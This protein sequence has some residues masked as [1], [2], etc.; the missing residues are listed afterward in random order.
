VYRK[1][2]KSCHTGQ[3]LDVRGKEQEE[4]EMEQIQTV[5]IK[6]SAT[7]EATAVVLSLPKD[8]ILW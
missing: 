5:Q 7:K 8:T 4:Q 6:Q 3:Y 2:Q 1:D